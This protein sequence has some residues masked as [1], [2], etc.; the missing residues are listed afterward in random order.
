MRERPWHGQ[1]TRFMCDPKVA[2]FSL[3]LTHFRDFESGQGWS[4][5]QWESKIYIF[6]QYTYT[7]TVRIPFFILLRNNEPQKRITVFERYFF[8]LR[9]TN[10]TCF[11]Y[12]LS[13]SKSLW[14]PNEISL[15]S[16]TGFYYCVYPFILVSFHWWAES[17]CSSGN[18]NVI[19]SKIGRFFR[20][21]IFQWTIKKWGSMRQPI[22]AVK[23]GYGTSFIS[24]LPKKIK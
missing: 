10:R 24:V 19:F 23:T 2:C 14:Q 7:Y 22:S 3:S 15:L 13:N 20:F 18:G 12:P 21:D 11:D 6:I 5:W 17:C 8:V 16:T 4:W 1:W 9:T